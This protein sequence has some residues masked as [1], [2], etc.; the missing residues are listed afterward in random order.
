MITV[1][2]VITDGIKEYTIEKHIGSGGF[3]D[4][5]KATCDGQTYA[6]KVLKDDD[7][8]HIVS[9]RNEFDI[10]SK[11][12]SEHAVRY[13]YLNEYGQNEYPSF[14][15]MEYAGDGSLYEELQYRQSVGEP[16]TTAELLNI[17]SQLIDGMID[18]SEVAVHRD[19]KPQNI[20]KADVKYKISDY[21]LAK[22]ANE[23][24]RSDSKTMKGFGTELYYAPELWADPAAHGINDAKVDIY[25]MGIVF[26]Q[27]ANLCYPYDMIAN[28]RTMHMYSPIK[29]F[30]KDVDP[31][32][33]SLIRKM[34]EKSKAK[35]FDTW[36]QIKDFISNSSVGSGMERDPFVENMLKSTMAKQQAIDA[37]VS[38]ET[39][40]NQDRI[41][42]FRR[43]VYQINEEIYQPLKRIVEQF[44]NDSSR[45]KAILSEMKIDDEDE[46]FSFEYTLQAL[47]D[48]DEERGISFLFESKHTE[49]KEAT[50]VF[51]LMSSN[52]YYNGMPSAI[53]QFG[54]YGSRIIDYKYNKDKI[55]LWGTIEAD[56][57]TGFN[58]AI[59]ED[60]DDSLYG[61]VKSFIRTANVQ[62]YES[63]WFPIEPSKLRELCQYGFSEMRYTT[64]V[65]DFNFDL[66]KTLMGQNDVYKY[67]SIKDPVEGS[68]F[69][70][71]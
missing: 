30:G 47:S 56:C 11:V 1:G 34:M 51:P 6:V 8:N 12:L 27:L 32:F 36:S 40:E 48:E 4:V 54:K 70:R 57:G 68:M 29:A 58:V 46:E 31:A 2:S 52:G 21:G 55:L 66:V 19:I 14:I 35:R 3:A 53:D 67:G 13:F 45:R 26:Y 9:I 63:V 23:A 17:F 16:Y 20:L 37:R 50:R 61:K 18:I 28:H 15:I 41:D 49:T 7:A 65:E 10:A 62:G 5:Y 42:S 43:L 71:Y 60:P 39:K 38:K 69:L 59:F 24:T 25:A 64:N 33:E 22:Y 44:N